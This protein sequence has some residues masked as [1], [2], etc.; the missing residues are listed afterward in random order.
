MNA[1]HEGVFRA[2]TNRI[3]ELCKSAA[4]TD[5][6]SRSDSEHQPGE[7]A[8]SAKACALKLRIYWYPGSI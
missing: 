3:A 7:R 1:R 5:F 2:A 6:L 8:N 4:A